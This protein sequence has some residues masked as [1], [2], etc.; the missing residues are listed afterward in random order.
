MIYFARCHAQ[1]LHSLWV[2]ERWYCFCYPCLKIKERFRYIKFMS[3]W[4]SLKVRYECECTCEWMWDNLMFSLGAWNETQ[5]REKSERAVSV[6]K[7]EATEEAMH[8][9]QTQSVF[10]NAH[11]T[12]AINAYTLAYISRLYFRLSIFLVLR[13]EVYLV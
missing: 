7:A 11:L 8:A 6:V 9:S 2:L 1:L 3:I 5:K 13:T 12:F 10:I 4:E